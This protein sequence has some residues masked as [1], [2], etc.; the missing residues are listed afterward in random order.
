MGIGVEQHNVIKLRFGYAEFCGFAVPVPAP[1]CPGLNQLN[2]GLE[3][4]PLA[5]AI[6]APAID[7]NDLV[8]PRADG[9][10]D[11]FHQQAN[12]KERVVTDGYDADRPVHLLVVYL[13]PS[14]S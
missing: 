5:R 13:E 8:A 12:E 10:P 6:A 3:A 7:H 4:E 14:I 2:I 1:I 9:L 11:A